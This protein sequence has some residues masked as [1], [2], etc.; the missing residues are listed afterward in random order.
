MPELAQRVHLALQDGGEV[1]RG[2]APR[3]APE[4]QEQL[5]GGG[6][7]GLVAPRS[8]AVFAAAGQQ[9]DRVFALGA[10]ELAELVDGGGLPRLGF[11]DGVGVAFRAR[12]FHCRFP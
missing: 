2:H 5:L 3:R 9:L 1:T 11:Q 4:P 8:L 6:R 12:V 10:G 7:V